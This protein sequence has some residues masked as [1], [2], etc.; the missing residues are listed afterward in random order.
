[1]YTAISYV[2][3][4]KQHFILQRVTVELMLY[5]SIDCSCQI[6]VKSTIFHS[7]V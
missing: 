4:C 5:N 6:N 1:M 2:L 7:I 3:M